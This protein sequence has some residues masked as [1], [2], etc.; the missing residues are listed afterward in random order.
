MMPRTKLE[1]NELIVTLYKQE[2]FNS[3][4]NSET[5]EMKNEKLIQFDRIL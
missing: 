2:V 5:K 1:V 3:T 4:V